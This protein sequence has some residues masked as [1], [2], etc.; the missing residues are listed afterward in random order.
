[1]FMTKTLF[2]QSRKTAFLIDGIHNANNFFQL[3]RFKIVKENQ[4]E[5]QDLNVK[6]VEDNVIKKPD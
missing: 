6:G 3:T 4:A 1:M 5:I 2:H